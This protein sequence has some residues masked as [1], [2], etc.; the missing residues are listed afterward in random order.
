MQTLNQKFFRFL[1]SYVLCVFGLFVFC[2]FGNFYGVW[3]QAQCISMRQISRLLPFGRTVHAV[4]SC[5]FFIRRG[6]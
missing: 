4:D 6:S 2:S 1:V 5:N 3:M